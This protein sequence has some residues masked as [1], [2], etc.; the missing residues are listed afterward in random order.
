MN[1]KQL[2]L[3]LVSYL[4]F[5]TVLSA[6]E[7]SRFTIS[8][9]ETL[10]LSE[11]GTGNSKQTEVSRVNAVGQVELLWSQAVVPD[12]KGFNLKRIHAAGHFGDTLTIIF[13]E[14]DVFLYL[15][16]YNLLTHTRILD[17]AS[18]TGLMIKFMRDT[19][20]ISVTDV[21]QVTFS[22]L[23]SPATEVLRR[24]ENRQWLLNGQPYDPSGH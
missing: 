18:V 9:N 16:N 11:T 7:L 17:V 13:I 10:V 5:S 4:I 1:M 19:G 22:H 8:P 20:T 23:I 12:D 3:L 15:V 2:R 24:L 14:N 6:E 21:G